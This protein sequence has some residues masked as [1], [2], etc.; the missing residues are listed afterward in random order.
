MPITMTDDK[1]AGSG[2]STPEFVDVAFVNALRNRVENF[3]SGIAA[4]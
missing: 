2:Q 4:E 3:R 1:M